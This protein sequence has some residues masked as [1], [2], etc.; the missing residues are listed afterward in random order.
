MRQI[1]AAPDLIEVLKGDP[2]SGVLEQ[3]SL[4]LQMMAAKQALPSLKTRAGNPSPQT[5]VWILGAIENL[6]TSSDVPFF[7]GF[8]D[9][10]DPYVAEVAAKAIERFTG[11]DFGFVRCGPGPCV[12][13]ATALLN[14]QNWW[15]SQEF[16]RLRETRLIKTVPLPR[17]LP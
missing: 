9:D 3:I 6:G 1:S 10:P 2:D 8:L 13:S 11:Q 15:R 17:Y 14:A 4:A 16:N 12:T 7:A 5:R